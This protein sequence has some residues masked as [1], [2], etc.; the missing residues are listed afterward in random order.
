MGELSVAWHF[1]AQR[2]EPLWVDT[3]GPINRGVLSLARVG[4]EWQ[5]AF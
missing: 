5:E 4:W 2:F 3:R 1:A